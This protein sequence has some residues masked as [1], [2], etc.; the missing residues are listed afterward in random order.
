LAGFPGGEKNTDG[1]LGTG[2]K[3]TKCPPGVENNAREDGLHGRETELPEVPC[4]PPGLFDRRLG[5]LQSIF[6]SCR[7][8]TFPAIGT[9]GFS[10]FR[11]CLLVSHES[12]G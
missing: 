5:L 12:Y 8:Q 1:I 6:V 7:H 10:D 11:V 3:T 9:N 2:T 4:D